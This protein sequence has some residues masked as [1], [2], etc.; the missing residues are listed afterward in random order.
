VKA[1]TIALACAA[2]LAATPARSQ[3]GATY[4]DIVDLDHDGRISLPEYLERFSYAF[5]QMDRNHDGVVD[6]GEQ[7]I[8]GAPRMTLVQLHAQLTEQ[9]HRQDKNHD[10]ALSPREFLAP[11]G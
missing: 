11:P 1:A 5:R 7:E 2:L 6:T 10:G 4:F 8:P 9:F 3:S